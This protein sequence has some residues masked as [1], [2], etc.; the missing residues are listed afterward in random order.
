MRRVIVERR[1]SARGACAGDCVIVCVE[2]EEFLSW[3]ERVVRRC[4][5]REDGDRVK[6]FQE[7]VG[8]LGSVATCVVRRGGVWGEVVVF[9]RL[10]FAS[11]WVLRVRDFVVAV[12][13]V[14]VCV[15]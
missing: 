11:T 7:L 1:S 3:A 13:E 15:T 10:L 14:E 2:V 4:R 9:W 8:R 6:G 5:E 12:F